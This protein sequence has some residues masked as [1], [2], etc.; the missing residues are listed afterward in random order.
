[1]SRP[2]TWSAILIVTLL[3]LFAVVS[4]YRKWMNAPDSSGGVGF[5]LSDLRRLHREGKM[6]D[7]EFARAKAL[8]IGNVKKQAEDP[9]AGPGGAGPRNS[10]KPDTTIDPKA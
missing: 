2:L 9:A 4:M 3:V 8:I 6:T 10:V 7:E 1:M 5:T